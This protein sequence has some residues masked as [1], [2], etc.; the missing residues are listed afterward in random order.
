MLP[1][2]NLKR[3]N[4]AVKIMVA[5]GGWNEGSERFSRVAATAEQRKLFVSQIIAMLKAYNFDGL[6]VDWEYPGQR[7][8]ASNDKVNIR[9]I[10]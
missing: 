10:C 5:I 8:G 9:T 4:S 7:G 6:D 2:Q 3:R 1:L